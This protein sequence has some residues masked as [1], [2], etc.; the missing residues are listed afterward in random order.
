MGQAAPAVGHDDMP[1]FSLDGVT[2]E[3]PGR[4]LL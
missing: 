4:T 3:V 1:L 2:M